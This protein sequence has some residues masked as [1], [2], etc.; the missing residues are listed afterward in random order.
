MLYFFIVLFITLF[1]YDIFLLNR[2][3]FIENKY[4]I[5]LL[6]IAFVINTYVIYNLL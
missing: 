2:L 3:V 4:D 6:C 1:I 5:I